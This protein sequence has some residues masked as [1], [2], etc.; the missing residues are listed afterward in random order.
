MANS[1]AGNV[2]KVDTDATTLS[3]VRDVVAIKYIGNTSGTA[4][5]KKGATGGS[6]LWQESGSANVFNEVKITSPTGLYVN[7]TNGAVIYIYMK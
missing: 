6:L 5:I 2:V 4:T 1:R 7:L 3:D